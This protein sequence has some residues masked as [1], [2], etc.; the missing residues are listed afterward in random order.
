[1]TDLSNL[2][3]VKRIQGELRQVFESPSGQE[4]MKFLEEIC[5][6]Y[7]FSREEPNAILMAHGKR[8]VLATLKTLLNCSA[9]QVQLVAKQQGVANG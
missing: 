5:G 7:D 6:W 4:V 2:S 1:M 9:E 3:H 8:Q